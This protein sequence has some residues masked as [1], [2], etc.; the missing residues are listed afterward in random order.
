MF[1]LVV[2]ALS[3]TSPSCPE[4]ESERP[5]RSEISAFAIGVINDQVERLKVAC[6]QDAW[7]ARLG[8]HDWQNAGSPSNEL[9]AELRERAR[10]ICAGKWVPIDKFNGKVHPLAD[11]GDAKHMYEERGG[12]HGEQ[13]GVRD[14]KDA[15]T[16]RRHHSVYGDFALPVQSSAPAPNPWDGRFGDQGQPHVDIPVIDGCPPR[17]EWERLSMRGRPY[18]LRGC[19]FESSP[20]LRE[21]TTEHLVAIAGNHS[22][23]YCTESLEEHLLGANRHMRRDKPPDYRNCGGLPPAL[24]RDVAVPM[25]L[26]KGG[27]MPYRYDKTVLWS[28]AENWQGRTSPLHFDLHENYMQIVWGNKRLELVDPVESVLVYGDFA[29]QAHGNSPVSSLGPDLLRYPLAAQ[30]TLHVAE[31]EPGDIAFIPYMWW[32]IVTTH[33][34]QAALALTAQAQITGIGDLASADFSAIRAEA[35][36][37]REEGKGEWAKRLE[38]SQDAV[39]VRQAMGDFNDAAASNFVSF[40]DMFGV[41]YLV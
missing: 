10:A 25:P 31:L 23:R 34:P 3:S 2:L 14:A 1:A 21:W 16:R 27:P 19:A 39:V 36:V 40:D 35:Q 30:A 28:A 12:V 9:T 33:H 18:V 4:S 29:T 22:G 17:D 24:M 38:A 20:R 41:E 11:C 32:H 37:L 26:R 15:C 8:D 13:D 7:V 6:K 5:G